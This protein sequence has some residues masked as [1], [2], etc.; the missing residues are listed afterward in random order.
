MEMH[1]HEFTEI[2]SQR[3]RSPP[4]SSLKSSSSLLGPP[5]AWPSSYDLCDR[6]ALHPPEHYGFTIAS[7]VEPTT[8]RE[9]AAH[10]DWQHAMSEEIVSLEHTGT[11]DLVPLLP[12][13]TPITCKWVYKI[14]TRF[15][16]LLLT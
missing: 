7:L 6:G 14:K 13:A 11:W 5:P 2:Y 4:P 12:H 10:P 8:Y 3:T 16:L 9:T 1:A 15:L